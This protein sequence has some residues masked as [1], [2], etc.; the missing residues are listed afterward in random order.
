MKSSVKFKKIKNRML[1]A[2]FALGIFLVLYFAAVFLLPH[3][4]FSSKSNNTKYLCYLKSNG[5]HVDLVMPLK[6]KHYDWMSYLSMEHIEYQDST[7]QW[8]AFGWGDK[9]FYLNT[10]TWGDLTFSTA[11][12][13]AF[14]LSSG[15][16]HVTYYQDISPSEKCLPIHLNEN[17][18]AE[19]HDFILNDFNLNDAK[20]PIHIPTNMNYGPQDCFYESTK[21]YSL[22]HTCNTWVNDALK[23][24]EANHCL[25][26]ALE[27]GV[28]DLYQNQK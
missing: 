4:Q 5:S 28:M 9:N 23:D 10:P 17:Q 6:T 27:F 14:W 24:I 3:I 20:K 25:W 19:L 11:F 2:L 18:M 13:A 1:Q 26:T 12:K 22:F 21:K 16:I 8:V 15:A 7:F